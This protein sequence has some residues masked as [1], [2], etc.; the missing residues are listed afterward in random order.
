LIN[1]TIFKKAIIS[2]ANNLTKN[3]D[4]VNS[5]NI[6]PVPDGDTGTNMSM[7]INSAVKELNNFEAESVSEVADKVASAMLRGA[8]GNS[9]V[10]LSLLFRGISKGLKDM[11]MVN[12]AEFVRA[13]SSGVTA[14][15]D[16]VAKPTE[17][18]ILT[19]ARVSQEKG[20]EASLYNNDYI[21]VWSQVLKGAEEALEETPKLLPVLKKAGVV[22][23]GGKGLCLIFEGMQSVFKNNE[24]IPPFEEEKSG[25]SLINKSKSLLNIAAELDQDINFT[26]CTEFIVN[27]ENLKEPEEDKIEENYYSAEN[28]KEFLE[29]IG[30]C[31][32]LVADEE[33][34]KVHVHTENPG[35]ALQEALKIG[36]L[37]TIKIE[38][39]KE[40]NRLLREEREKEQEKELE[41]LEPEKDFGFVAV[42]SGDG[43]VN[44]FKDLSCD[45]IIS[46]GQTMNPS[47]DKILSG[48]LATP[49]RTVFVLPNNKNI[50]LSA[51][52][53]IDLVKDRR[54]VIIPTKTI[55]QGI[56]AMLAFNSELPED[57]NVTAMVEAS[58]KVKTG[59]ITFASRDAEFGGFKI[60][61]GEILALKDGKLAFKSKDPIKALLKLFFSMTN[62]KT[63]FVTLI[64]G[65]L[66]DKEQAESVFKRLQARI[67]FQAEVSLIDGGQPVYHF[68]LSVE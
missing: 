10:I 53:T 52:Q 56:S 60:K 62:K 33:I 49:A 40:Q 3:K 64:Y 16:A 43:I 19:V 38:N 63:K 59:Q 27:K 6:F 65:N 21:Y 47:T 7:T 15:Y 30:D 22:D 58:K 9:G 5:L 37:L 4:L 50:I 61:E 45:N 66:I 51:E 34:I 31:V 35:L 24:I 26:Y 23:S 57:E 25:P 32:V 17:G 46:G 28:L 29:T 41:I 42:C 12:G 48:I 13:L 55:P 14:A 54:V 18:T 2:G 11:K 8:R 1:G 44:I 67:G 68:I 20:K 36:Q 39:M